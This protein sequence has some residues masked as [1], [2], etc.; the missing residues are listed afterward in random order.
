MFLPIKLSHFPPC[1]FLYVVHSVWQPEIDLNKKAKEWGEK[2][3]RCL[4]YTLTKI[5]GQK[6]TGK[7]RGQ[8]AP[9]LHARGL[10]QEKELTGR[11]SAASSSQTTAA[12]NEETSWG[13]CDMSPSFSISLFTCLLLFLSKRIHVRDMCYILLPLL[14]YKQLLFS[15][16]HRHP[17]VRFVKTGQAADAQMKKTKINQVCLNIDGICDLFCILEKMFMGINYQSFNVNEMI[18]FRCST[19]CCW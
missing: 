10:L 6:S 13:C 12:Q 17:F 3:R 7:E 1:V 16:A 18:L 15:D 5:R 14:S 9:A 11:R 4:F 2:I 8:S 19:Y